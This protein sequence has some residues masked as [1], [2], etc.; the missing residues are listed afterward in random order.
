MDP[1]T[2]IL[3]S[4]GIGGLG[5]IIGGLFGKSGQESANAANLQI[6]RE[7]RAWQEKMS[8]T[9]N[10]RA[11][12]DLEAA[13][14]NRILAMGKPATTP[15]GNIATM[16]NTKAALQQGVA[17]TANIAAN[18]ALQIAQAQKI[19]QETQTSGTQASLNMTAAELNQSKDALAQ[20]Q[21]N[22][23]NEQMKNVIETRTGITFKNKEA[24][25]TQQIRKLQIA[26]VQSESEFYDWLMGA[27]ANEIANAMGKAG[28][29]VLAAIRA[30]FVVNRGR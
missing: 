9:A 17:Q 11:A 25:Y 2:A 14:L 27:N 18:T 20:M 7:N 15:S 19:R 28:P 5:N 3:A 29:L 12:K 22:L 1:A 23:T 10:Q 21:S 24:D 26:K 16:Q 6:A 4:A 13:G 8:N 30:F